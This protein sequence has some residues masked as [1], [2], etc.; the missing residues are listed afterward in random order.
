[1]TIHTP[2]I[3]AARAAML[4]EITPRKPSR[5]AAGGGY[6]LAIEL[7]N[8]RFCGPASEIERLSSN[9]VNP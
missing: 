9:A 8:G 6:I 2:H 1:V 4:L 3:L 7:P 5:L